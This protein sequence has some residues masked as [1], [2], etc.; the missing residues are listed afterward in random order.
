MAA[1]GQAIVMVSSDLPEL[2]G[3]CDRLAVMTRGAL[4][5]VRPISDWTEHSVMAVATG[6]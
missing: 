2:L 4:S 6:G 5:E 3:F 1:A